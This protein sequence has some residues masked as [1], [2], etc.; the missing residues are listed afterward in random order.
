MSPC[1]INF[2]SFWDRIMTLFAKGSHIYVPFWPCVREKIL[3]LSWHPTKCFVNVESQNQPIE[4][5]EL[6]KIRG[7]TDLLK[8]PLWNLRKGVQDEDL[9]TTVI[10][11]VSVILLGLGQNSSHGTRDWAN[12]FPNCKKTFARPSPTSFCIFLHTLVRR[13]MA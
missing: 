2:P 4:V 13:C 7:L 1:Q 8:L 10:S 6:H 12:V 5:S 9:S 3:T 11:L